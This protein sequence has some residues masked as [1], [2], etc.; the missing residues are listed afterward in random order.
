MAK[1]RY[2]TLMLKQTHKLAGNFTT[3]CDAEIAESMICTF[4]AKHGCAMPEFKIEKVAD[5]FY[6]LLQKL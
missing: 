6:R 2:N 1:P 5:N 3:R 4:A